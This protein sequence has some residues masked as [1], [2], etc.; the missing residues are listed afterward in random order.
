[1]SKFVEKKLEK[2]NSVIDWSEKQLDTPRK[3]RVEAVREFTGI[4]YFDNSA[5]REVI[6]PLMSLAILIYVRQ[7]AARSPRVLIST[8]VES[9]KYIAANLELA[10]NQIPDEIGL[11]ETLRK[12]V[13]EAIFSMGIVKCGLYTTSVLHGNEYGEMF[14]DLVTLD[15]YFFDMAAD[16]W[17]DLDY[18]GN[19]YWLDYETIQ[20]SNYFK[21]KD[22]LKA[23]EYRVISETGQDRADSITK[24]ATSKTYRKKVLLRDI[25]LPKEKL[26]IT[27]SITDKKLLAEIE[28][29]GPEFGPYHKLGFIDVPGNLLPLPPVALWRG[30]HEL[31]NSTFRKLAEGA[32]AYKKVQ[33]FP[34]GHDEDVDAFQKSKHG[35]GIKF[36][37][38]AK[39][40]EIEAGGINRELFAF[41]LQC[42]ELESYISGNID[43][44]GGLAPQTQTI[45]QD[46]LLNE[47][48]GIQLRYMSERVVDVVR[49]IFRA[50]A[51]YEWNDPVKRRTLLKP[52]PKFGNS[53]NIEFGPEDKTGELN[54][55]DL[56][57]DVYSIQD[58][59]PSIK[60][61]KIRTIWQQDILPAGQIVQQFGGTINPQKYY[62]LLAKYSNT[63]EVAEMIE[64]TEQSPTQGGP[65]TPALPANTTR[66]YERVG[67][68]G[69][70]PQGASSAIQQILL[71]GNP[72]GENQ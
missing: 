32:R 47:S 15:N 10:L 22:D 30:L 53:I 55:Y 67:R 61:Q 20:D 11:D 21:N 56:D 5:D 72:G 13:M 45:G 70:T 35:W 62:E 33:G 57:I 71:G 69:A 64:F 41:A 48:A 59:S 42:K 46:R 49:N 23:D 12:F 31:T 66:T 26:L 17:D 68:P 65:S 28:W 60:L 37:Q 27:Q 52:V 58:E 18:E 14:V 38:A 34:G 16:V 2:L 39:P 51:F 1:M 24:P 25:W 4:H 8:K 29:E 44:L 36:D 19:K 7:L 3:K 43:T 63:P 54:I 6:L 50:L 9:K 40:Q